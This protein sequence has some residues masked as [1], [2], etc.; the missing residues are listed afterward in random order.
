LAASQAL[1]AVFQGAS[2]EVVPDLHQIGEAIIQRAA[3]LAQDGEEVLFVA[4]GG[5]LGGEALL[6]YPATRATVLVEVGRPRFPI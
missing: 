2:V 5:G 4:N 3:C 6:A 1:F